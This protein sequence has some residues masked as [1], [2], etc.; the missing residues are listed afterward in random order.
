[1]EHRRE[2]H[3]LLAAAERRLL[4]HVARRLPPF[5]N[6]DQ[7]TVL[8]FG[9]M[10]GAGA[11]FAMIARTPWAAMAVVAL[12]AVNWFGDSLDGTLARVRNCQR[13]RYGYYV[14]HVVDLA[15][16]AALLAGMSASRLMSPSI[17]LGVLAAYFAVAAEAYLGTHVLGVFRISVAG[18]GPTELR[19]VLAAGALKVAGAPSMH[20]AGREVLVLDVGGLVACVSLAG[21]FAASAARNIVA[22]YRAE[23][24]P[25]AGSCGNFGRAAG[26]AL[27]TDRVV[28]QG[29]ER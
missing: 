4:I 23:P 8:A 15:G 3:S 21:A 27:D 9:A 14:D 24:L 13:P 17:A 18:I 2:H 5:V 29:G 6:S 12:L 11:A 19:L 10:V 25:P 22:L 7:L 26:L 28:H 1:M 20:L 16:T